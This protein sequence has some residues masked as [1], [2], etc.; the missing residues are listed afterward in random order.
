MHALRLAIADGITAPQDTIVFT[1]GVIEGATGTTNTMRVMR[2]P[3][4]E[5]LPPV[6]EVQ[7]F[8]LAPISRRN[9]IALAL[10]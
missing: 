3:A 9:S 10:E 6:D 5:E 4:V 2:C 1:A 8:F 7:T